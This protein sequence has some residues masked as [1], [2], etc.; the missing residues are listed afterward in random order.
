VLSFDPPRRL[1]YDYW[2]SMSGE[3]DVIDRRPIIVCEVA[4][5]D[6]ATRLTIQQSNIATEE[7]AE[8][9]AKNWQMVLDGLK[10]V[11]EGG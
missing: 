10:H 11:V 2:S 3:A 5:E 6:G 9:S 7:R 1:S 8:H 4:P